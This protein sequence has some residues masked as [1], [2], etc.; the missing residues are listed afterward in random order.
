MYCCTFRYMF[1]ILKHVQCFK[2]TARGWVWQTIICNT[3]LEMRS[4]KQ[5]SPA[6][7]H[8]R[9]KT[10]QIAGDYYLPPS[11]TF[12]PCLNYH[13]TSGTLDLGRPGAACWMPS[14]TASSRAPCVAECGGSLVDLLRCYRHLR[15]N[16]S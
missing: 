11:M 2:K 7:T 3:V 9:T 14:P 6:L 16:C 10:A 15:P 8:A 4:W 13:H 1:D 5:L 12:P